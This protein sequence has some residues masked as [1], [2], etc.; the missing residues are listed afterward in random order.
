MAEALSAREESVLFG[1][2]TLFLGT[3]EPVGSKA[4]AELD[5]EGL[6]PATIR[7]IMAGL[8]EKGFLSKPH[9][10]AGRVPTDEA[11]RHFA[12]AVAQRGGEAEE[13]GSEEVEQLLT[14]GGLPGV[15]RELSSALA[16]EV[17]T[18]GF[19]VTPTLGSVRLR[20]CELVGLGEGRIL[21]VV[22][23]QAGQ[24][25]EKVLAAPEPYSPEQLR[26][27]SNYLD[28]A[29]AGCTFGEI[30]RRLETQ[31]QLELARCD[32]LI[33]KALLLVA[34]CFLEFPESRE[35]FWDGA[36]WLL[37]S[38]ALQ[39]DL[40]SVK[41]LLD[42]LEKKAHL[43][44][45]LQA[46]ISDSQPVRVVLG[47]DWPDASVRDLAMVAAPFGH[48][49]VGHGFLGVIG[50]KALRYDTAISRVRQAAFLATLASSRL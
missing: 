32:E 28:E 38:P 31:V 17:H 46:L 27:F 29:F 24:V 22:V 2:V 35:L 44:A 5:P 6:S 47:E 39:A 25:H 14:E 36:P 43:I 19:A 9:T 50:P 30:R 49:A 23:S 40:G 21:C 33:R 34:P 10:S 8:E 15:A 11:Y 20:A 12:E 7:S 42:S 45:L 1:L 18:L 13:P 4:L 3:Q 41:S 48:E 26:W 37:D 16:R